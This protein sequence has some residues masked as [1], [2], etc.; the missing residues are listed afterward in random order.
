MEE[1][2][3]RKD[4]YI[5]FLLILKYIP[6]MTAIFYIIYTIFQLVDVDLIW[7]GYFFHAS[8]MSLGFMYLTSYI[9]KYCYVH[10]LP[11]HYISINELLSTIDYYIGIPVDDIQLIL[12][13]ICLI[14]F[15]IF[16]YTFYYVKSHKKRSLV[17]H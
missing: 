12:V 4:K 5:N 3:R 14:G 1:K 17:V 2:L 11:L 6:H 8:Y 13:H 16:G 7:F 9:F 15:L 10:R